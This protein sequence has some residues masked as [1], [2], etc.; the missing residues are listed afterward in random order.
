MNGLGIIKQS[1]PNLGQ[2]ISHANTYCPCRGARLNSQDGHSGSKASNS[3]GSDT[4]P[5]SMSTTY[6][7]GAPIYTQVKHSH[8]KTSQVFSLIYMKV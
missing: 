7:C 5:T 2:Q 3:R 6:T 1:N 8:I 4:L